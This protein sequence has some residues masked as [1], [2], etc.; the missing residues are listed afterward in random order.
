[1]HPSAML[2]DEAMALA[3]LEEQALAEEDVDKAE[4]LANRR[5]GL[6]FDAWRMRGGYDENLLT[7]RLHKLQAMQRHLQTRAES[8]RTKLAGQMSTERKQAK[9]FNGYR[10]AAAQSQKAF[11]FDKRS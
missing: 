5:A 11:Y 2:L 6:L 8:L 7:E 3:G 1:M 4:E 10:H 9:Y